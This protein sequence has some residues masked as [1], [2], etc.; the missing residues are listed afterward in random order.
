MYCIGYLDANAFDVEKRL[1]EYVVDTIEPTGWR[2]KWKFDP[3]KNRP[4]SSNIK[5]ADYEYIV[6]VSIFVFDFIFMLKLMSI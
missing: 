6:D 3:I 1:V 4:D 2:A 5:Y